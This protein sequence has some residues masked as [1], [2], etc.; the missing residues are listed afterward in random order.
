MFNKI[1]ENQSVIKGETY[2]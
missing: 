1:D 2:N